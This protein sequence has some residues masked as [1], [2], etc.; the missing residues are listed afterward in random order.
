VFDKLRYRVLVERFTDVAPVL[1]LL[2]R[3]MFP[4][5]YVVPGQCHNNLLPAEDVVELLAE[6]ER[7]EALQR[8]APAPHGPP[9]NEFS[10]ASYRSINWIADYPVKITDIVTHDLFTFEL[11][12][13]VYVNVELQLLDQDTARRNEEGEN[14]H[15]LYK[16]RQYDRVA[17]RLKRGANA[18]AKSRGGR[19]Q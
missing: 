14:A 15:A 6:D 13:V 12:R 10:G 5:N 7:R 8:T 18:S 9:R 16:A 11:G 3:E 17:T 4:F 19:S 1:G 2:A